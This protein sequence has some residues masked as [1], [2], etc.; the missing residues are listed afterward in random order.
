MAKTT[1]LS[2]EEAVKRSPHKWVYLFSEGNATMRDLLAG[3][4]AGV[5]E[6]TD[7]GLPVPPALRVR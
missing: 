6:M 2:L 5:G 3:K 4:G 1:A 7:A